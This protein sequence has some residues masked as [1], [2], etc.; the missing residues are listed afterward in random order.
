M[1]AM[2]FSGV[3]LSRYVFEGLPRPDDILLARRLHLAGAFWS[4]IL[5]SL[6]LALHWDMISAMASRG[7]SRPDSRWRRTV[8]SAAA[9]AIALYGLLVFFRR[10]FPTYLLLQSEF[11]FL[12]FDEPPLLFYIDYLSLMGTCIFIAHF[13]GTM[14]KKL[15]TTAA[16]TSG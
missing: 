16:Q 8:L 10:D 3:T 2:I 4:Y 13:G 1:L 15:S 6:H 14:L 5:M 9:F 7:F 12:D 11:A